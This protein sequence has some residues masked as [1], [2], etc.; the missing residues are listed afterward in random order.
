MNECVESLKQIKELRWRL[1]GD[2]MSLFA[3]KGLHGFLLEGK[4]VVHCY[5]ADR[6]PTRREQT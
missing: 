5:Y 1:W 2:E 4:P 6:F 3:Q